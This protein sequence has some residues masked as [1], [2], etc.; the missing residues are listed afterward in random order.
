MHRLSSKL[1]IKRLKSVVGLPDDADAAQHVNQL[2]DTMETTARGLLVTKRGYEQ[3]MR[4]FCYEG[5]A[6]KNNLVRC[7]IVVT[8]IRLAVLLVYYDN[9]L[10]S[11]VLADPIGEKS[12]GF[13][14]IAFAELILC[15][16]S[17]LREYALYLEESGA[18]MQLQIL[19][20]IQ[21]NGFNPNLLYLS[22][23][24][25]L[26]FQRIFIFIATNWTNFIRLSKLIAPIVLIT[27]KM[28]HPKVFQD[29]LFAQMTILWTVSEIIVARFVVTGL[30][31]TGGHL[32]ILF[33]W[34]VGRIST[35]IGMCKDLLQSPRIRTKE[36]IEFNRMAI[37]FL[38]DFTTNVTSLKLIFF[39]LFVIISFCA[40]S[41]IFLAIA[42]PLPDEMKYLLMSIGLI[43]LTIIGIVSYSA[44]GIVDMFNQ[45]H[46]LLIQIMP[47]SNSRLE[48]K[49][50][51]D[52]IICRLQWPDTA[53]K[54]GDFCIVVRELFVYYILENASTIMLLKCNVR[55][56]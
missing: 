27:L 30:L 10:V 52:E 46:G 29:K 31:N 21:R 14:L 35:L 50:K 42:A 5:Y 1:T 56:Q 53:P 54:I 51:V 47:R 7:V 43:G 26:K 55:T 49:L 33:P 3:Y 19:K 45:I 37:H 38:N 15:T 44:G 22:P 6:W 16:L 36:L 11:L 34:Y 2:I 39:Y 4:D 17:L 20:T 40:D 13:I 32:I 28:Q 12:V 23:T 48:S 24:E 25:N 41:I 18:I 8:I 9:E